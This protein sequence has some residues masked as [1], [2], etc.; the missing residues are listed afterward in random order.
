M[1]EEG[2]VALVEALGLLPLAA[3]C[4]DGSDSS[5]TLGCVLVHIRDVV[6]SLVRELVSLGLGDDG[7]H[8]DDGHDNQSGNCTARVDLDEAVGHVADMQHDLDEEHDDEAGGETDVLDVLLRAAHQLS[9][10]VLPEEVLVLTEDAAEGLL[11]HA[12]LHGR[13]YAVRGEFLDVLCYTCNE[14]DNQHGNGDGEEQVST[15]ADHACVDY[16]L[17]ISRPQSTQIDAEYQKHC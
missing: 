6:R 12:S 15:A 9:G 3:E 1:L 2:P 7:Q 17:Y 4:L 11:S 13:A 10:V 14:I 16:F 8:T 5:E